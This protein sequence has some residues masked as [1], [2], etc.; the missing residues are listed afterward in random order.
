MIL[1]IIEWIDAW[2]K[3]WGETSL[4]TDWNGL[5]RLPRESRY[6]N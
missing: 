3:S 4:R 2:N 6:L 1:N 5:E